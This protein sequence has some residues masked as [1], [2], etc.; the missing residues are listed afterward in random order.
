N[1]CDI[2]IANRVGKKL[3]EMGRESETIWLADDYDPLRKVP[4]P[5]PAN[6][7]K[8]L[9]IPYYNIPCPDNCCSN[10]VEHFEKP[11]FEVL[12][13]YGIDLTYYSLFETYKK[14]LYKDYIRTA[15]EKSEKIRKIF[16]QYREHPLKSD[17]LPY[18]PIC[19]KCGRVNTTHSYDFNGDIVSY[20]C[21]CGYEGEI[22][23]KSGNGKLT[24]RV[25]WAARW[26]IFS[27]IC[28]PFG[29]DH[30]T[31][32]GSY[33]VSKII[34]EEIFNYT[35]PYPIP[36]EWISLDGEAMSKS[37]G[38]FFTPKQ[39]LSIGPPESLN[40]F[41]FRSKPMKHKDFSP[42]MN[43]LSF[44]DQFDK[45]EKVYYD[46][47]P[48]PSEKEGEKFKTIYEI[49]KITKNDTIPFRPAY[50]FLSVAYQIAGKNLEK[51]YEILKKNSQLTK[52]FKNKDFQD[53]N[54]KEL[55]D[56]ENRL[57]NVINW[58]DNYAPNFVKFKVM[59]EIQKVELNEKEKEFLKDLSILIEENDFN[60]PTEL[61]DEMYKVIHNHD[62]KPQKAFKIIYKVI[63]NQ[64]KGPKAASFIMSLDKDFVIKR[65]RLES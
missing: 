4:Y 43:F 34:S 56:F 39:W 21:D 26:K 3:R 52:S 37:K 65:F 15:L 2:F 5:L 33:T 59:N 60:N 19:E 31:A 47:E 46:E 55:N 32:G 42:K 24:W 48:T 13:D 57:N 9:G 58:L 1:S 8:Y 12:D 28:E 50:G 64:S 17:W 38:V 51:I 11:L 10:F 40:Y 62:L 22:D 18:N 44:I 27:I 23:I 20:R 16:N 41:L 25:E 63:L 45:V 53:L 54:E 35:A 30:A 14:G 49:S 7:D 29:K 6:Y 61:H 36:Y